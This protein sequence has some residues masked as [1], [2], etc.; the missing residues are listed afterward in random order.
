MQALPEAVS[1]NSI[2][3]KLVKEN[4]MNKTVRVSLVLMITVGLLLALS[5]QG[6]AEKPE[7]KGHPDTFY[8]TY[9]FPQ[10]DWDIFYGEGTFELYVGDLEL[11]GNAILHWVPG[12]GSKQ[13]TM[14]LTVDDEFGS[15]AVVIFTVAKNE[16]D[17]CWSGPVS[18]EPLGT[19]GFEYYQGRGEILMCRPELGDWVYGEI[20]GWAGV[21]PGGE[22]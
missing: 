22:K 15:T 12:P 13:G 7:G 1:D 5:I 10:V 20:S 11:D 2:R 9:D 8:L 18:I 19:G 3:L 21:W 14:I 16:G 6:L 17:N 4:K